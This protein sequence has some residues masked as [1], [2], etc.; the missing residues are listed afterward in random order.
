MAAVQTFEV[1]EG[2]QGHLD[3]LSERVGSFDGWKRLEGLFAGTAILLLN[4]TC[5]LFF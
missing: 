2:L 5:S 1:R 4:M 3:G